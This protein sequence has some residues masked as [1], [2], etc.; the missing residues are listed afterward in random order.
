MTF[1]AA[2]YTRVSTTEQAA[3]DRVSLPDQERRCRDAA[4]SHGWQI[5]AEYQDAMSGARL[6]R[7][8]LEEMLADAKAN[9]FDL[10]VI[11]NHD[12][13]GR[14][15]AAQS[16]IA[17]ELAA[18][19]V[20]VFSISAPS[21]PQ[22]P[23]DFD[24]AASDTDLL[25]TAT[26][27]IASELWLRSHR[28]RIKMGQR[29]RAQRG[30]HW[31][32]LPYGYRR[33]L[34]D[35]GERVAI[36]VPEQAANL[37]DAARMLMTTA[38]LRDAVDLLR[39]RDP[40]TNWSNA[41]LSHLFTN[42]FLAG[43]IRYG[44]SRKLH[45]AD[46]SVRQITLP[47]DRWVI[48][49]GEH[50]PV[51]QEDEWEELQIEMERRRI[52]GERPRSKPTPFAGLVYCAHCQR[53]MR[54][55]LTIFATGERYANWSCSN[56]YYQR[57]CQPNF[58]SH[59]HFV[60]ALSQRMRADFRAHSREIE[61]SANSLQ[62]VDTSATLLQSFS[63]QLSAIH[64][65]L[66]RAYMSFESGRIALDLFDQ[67]RGALEQDLARMEARI[68]VLRAEQRGSE[69][70]DRAMSQVAELLPRLEEFLTETPDNQLRP[71]IRKLILRIWIRDKAVEWID[72]VA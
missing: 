13:L 53:K 64:A 61:E 7:P 31:G 12:R 68:A 67:R 60:Q 22:P 55:N 56:W 3:A 2:I 49:P 51:F 8:G 16:T 43:Q 39:S 38:S 4:E 47:R 18:A 5:I 37:Q 14:T 35:S 36:I 9:R 1:H 62:E 15:L 65:R 72:Y 63:S 10:L 24:P 42:P 71:A 40:G 44:Y 17:A 50:E 30:R 69:A 46:G 29:G 33:G 48:Y 27:A 34:S 45:E 26:S 70:R 23:D 59:K 32:R 66:E 58:L 25:I 20:Q 28:R 6:D 21:E 19:R 41:K 54:R 57:T 52:Q 11:Y